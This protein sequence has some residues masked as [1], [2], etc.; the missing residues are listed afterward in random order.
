MATSFFPLWLELKKERKRKVVSMMKEVIHYAYWLVTS[1]N[2]VP[3]SLCKNT[4]KRTQQL[5]ASLGQQCWEL[6]RPCWQ[7]CTNG[8]NNSQQCWDLQ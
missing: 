1:T 8:C 4:C 5:P 3:R 2:H 6:C 7:W